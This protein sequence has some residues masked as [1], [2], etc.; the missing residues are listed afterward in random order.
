MGNPSEAYRRFK[1]ST[2]LD[3]DAWKDGTPYDVAALDEMTEEERG[4]IATALSEKGQLDWRDVEALK[5]IGSPAA[6]AR[7]KLAGYE[8]SDGAGV[9]AFAADLENGWTP[10]Q[11]IRFIRKLGEARQMQ[12]AFDRLFRIAE[13]NPTQRVRDALFELATS[14]H[15]EVR[16]A[17]GAFLLY[18]NGHA[19]DWYGLSDKY[20][21]QLLD[22]GHGNDAER[23]AAAQWLRG[24]IAK[25]GPKAKA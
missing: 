5:R 23:A 8:Q 7:V 6:K 12:G 9:E 21:P 22:L 1:A 19:A 20:R 18:L 10:G 16:Y 2:A 13:A 11:E 24:K 3:F 17:Y 4:E 25:K 14:G 15:E